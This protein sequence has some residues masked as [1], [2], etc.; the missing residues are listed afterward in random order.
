MN[1]RI[2]NDSFSLF[3]KLAQTINTVGSVGEKLPISR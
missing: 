2:F 1:E 3:E